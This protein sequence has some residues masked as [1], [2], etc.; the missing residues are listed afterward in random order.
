MILDPLGRRGAASDL[1]ACRLGKTVPTSLWMARRSTDN[2]RK[3]VALGPQGTLIGE[4]NI[5]L[6]RNICWCVLHGQGVK[7]I[8]IGETPP[9]I[10]C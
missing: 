1:A 9:G 8:I 10:R 4:I 3:S 5:Y 2:Q 7:A 6:S